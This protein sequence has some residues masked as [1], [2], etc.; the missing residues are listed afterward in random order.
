MKFTKRTIFVFLALIYSFSIFAEKAI[1]IIGP[2][3]AGKGTQTVLL[4]NALSWPLLSPSNIIRE[5]RLNKGGMAHILDSCDP[6]R[7]VAEIIKL[8]ALELRLAE[9]RQKNISRP[10]IILDSWPKTALALPL[11]REAI[12][13][14]DM[15]L[16]IELVVS[17]ET[18]INRAVQRKVCPNSYC[19]KSYGLGAEIKPDGACSLCG[20]KLFQRKGDNIFN[21]P[22]RIKKFF[23][24]KEELVTQYTNFGYKVHKIDGEREQKDVH[25]DIMNLAYN[26]INN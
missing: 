24:R 15:P 10:G 23:K 7:I 19:G 2:P 12:F 22:Q 16:I 21:F 5:D 25:L 26:Y 13:K 6:P 9:Y 20:T 4:Q 3:G 17:E 14:D 18:L 1:I 8:G 11:A